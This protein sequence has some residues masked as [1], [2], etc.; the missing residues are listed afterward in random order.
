[1]LG[2]IKGVHRLL[3]LMW[4]CT[5]S[6]GMEKGVFTES[7]CCGD[8]GSLASGLTSS[9]VLLFPSAGCRLEDVLCLRL[10]MD[11]F[12]ETAMRRHG[13]LPFPHSIHPCM[14]CR[15]IFVRMRRAVKFLPWDNSVDLPDD[16]WLRLGVYPYP[17]S[18]QSCCMCLCC[19]TRSVLM[20]ALSY[21]LFAHL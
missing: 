16:A 15:C 7:S 2:Y 10:P 4:P 21:L 6:K 20:C 13:R 3:M 14:L 11:M 12:N 17:P 5:F 9:H 1:M 19:W 18:S 8:S